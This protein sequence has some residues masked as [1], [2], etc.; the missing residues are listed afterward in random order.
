MIA[1]LSGFLSSPTGLVATGALATVTVLIWDW[2]VALP[3]LFMVQ[4]A[5]SLITVDQSSAPLQWGLIQTAVMGLSCA[6]LGMSAARVMQDSPSSRQSGSFW[7]RLMTV[8]LLYGVWRLLDVNVTLPEMDPGFAQILG[9]LAICA[10]LL[11]GISTNPLFTGVAIMFWIIVVQAFVATVLGIPSLVA[12]VGILEL[13]VALA[14]SYLLVAER[15]PM[16]RAQP[17]TDIA[18]PDYLSYL[19]TGID[20]GAITGPLGDRV[21]RRLPRPRVTSAGGAGDQS[22]QDEPS[23]KSADAIVSVPHSAEVTEEASV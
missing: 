6:I 16:R 17:L 7:L 15:A 12:L 1:Q 23:T 22:K 11:L 18:F 9:W 8:M 5:V 20:I 21:R 2:R 13:S 4:A 10:L 3:V 19:E 14:C